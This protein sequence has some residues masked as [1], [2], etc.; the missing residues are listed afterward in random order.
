MEKWLEIIENLPY[1][2]SVWKSRKEAI[3]A[4]L[5]EKEILLEENRGLK[6]ELSQWIGQVEDAASGSGLSRESEVFHCPISSRD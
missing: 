3:R 5:Q 4:L 1:S 2:E 6:K